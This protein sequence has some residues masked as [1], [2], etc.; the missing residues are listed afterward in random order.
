MNFKI[1]NLIEKLRFRAKILFLSQDSLATCT[2]YKY[3]LFALF[4]RA[5]ILNDRNNY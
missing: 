3:I 5:N 2:Q 1:I 4:I